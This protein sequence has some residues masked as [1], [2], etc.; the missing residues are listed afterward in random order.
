M[1]HSA[2][3][4]HRHAIVGCGRVAPFHADAFQRLAG[5]ELALACDPLTANAEDLAARYAIAAYC[6]RFEDVLANPAVTSLSIATPH[7]LHAP[8]ALAAIE[9]GKHVL[10]EKPLALQGETGTAA[11]EAARKAGL[12][13]MPVA[14]HRFDPLIARIGEMVSAGDLGEVVMV[15]AHLECVRDKAYYR[16]SAW[17]GTWARE[18]GSVLMNQAH[19]LVDLLRWLGG[20]VRRVD[21]VMKTLANTD[22][23]ETEDMVAATLEFR[24][25]ASGTLSAN[26][27]AGGEWSSF[28]ELRGRAGIVAFDI[29]YPNMLHRF[30]LA[31]RRAMQR[32]RARFQDAQQGSIS[33]ALGRLSY[34]GTS[35]RAQA[36]AFIDAIDGRAPVEGGATAVEALEVAAIIQAIY[37]AARTGRACEPRPAGAPAPEIASDDASL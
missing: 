35:H 27:A 12:V 3:A 25:G 28:M 19:H 20:P 34:Y 22:V 30:Q 15:R 33:A 5:V 21:A 37:E 16:D 36:R 8:M 6:E 26:G 18:G 7:D 9:H 31:D 24:S 10:V 13:L 23:M 17:R 29:N 2:P 11:I 4:P 32:W 14:Q 1:S